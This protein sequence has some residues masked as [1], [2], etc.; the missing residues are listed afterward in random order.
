MEVFTKGRSRATSLHNEGTINANVNGQ[1]LYIGNAAGG[2]DSFVNDGLVLASHGGI[3]SVNYNDA[4]LRRG[5]TT[6]TAEISA[7]GGTLQLGAR[8]T[9]DGL[10]SGVNSTVYFGDTVSG[11]AQ[12]TGDIVVFGRQ[13]FPRWPGQYSFQPMDGLRLD[14][15]RWC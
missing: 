4:D 7:D 10:I 8:V 9:N 13:A 15:R 12:N 3:I 2:L 14:Q 6:P 5:P 11:L 1:T